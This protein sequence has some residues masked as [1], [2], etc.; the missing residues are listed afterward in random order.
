V[1][2]N[3]EEYHQK[4]LGCWMGKNIGG[5]LGAPFEWRR[6]LNNVSFYTQDLSGEPLPNDDLDIQLLWLVALEERGLD[7]DARTLSEYWTLYVT[8]HWSEYGTAKINLRS[9]L[10]PP[11]SGS[12]HN[13]YKDSC[14]SFIRS[15]IWACIAPGNPQV[16]TYYAYQ[17]A[18][19]DHGDGEG[20]YAEVFIA[21]LE[22]VAFVIS[23][24]RQLIEIALSYIPDSCG[25]SGAVLDALD[26]YRSGKTWQEARDHILANYR[27]STF[28][29]LLHHTSPED[30]AKGF[31]EGKRG[32]DAPSNIG[33][34]VIGLLYGEGDFAQSV[35]TAVNC[36]EDTDCTAAT[37]GSIFGILHGIQ[38]IPEK[39]IA[40]IGRKIKTACLNLGEL[41]NYGNQLP[42]D[43]DELTR[44]TEKIARQVILRYHLDMQLSEDQSSNLSGVTLTSLQAGRGIERLLENMKGPLY[45]FDFFEIA[46][47][48]GEGPL[49]RDNIPTLIR[50]RIYNTY[51]V[52]ATLNIHWY[53]PEGWQVSPSADGVVFSFP[54]HLGDPIELEYQVCAPHVTQSIN[55]AV[56]EITSPGRPTVM[57]LPIVFQN[58]NLQS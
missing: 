48:Y 18:I 56:V 31:G 58:G 25:V 39:W 46:I 54:V 41:G 29:N 45:T 35:C 50:L 22:S 38:A 49:L 14:G 21:A 11:L 4:V 37:A 8:P 47:D 7:L 23:D 40:P 20:V 43:V 3:F 30:W 57:L 13:Q 24:I 55:R 2:L 52:Q 34:L 42:A 19:L 33:M 26:S 28:F 12:L 15:E 27:G 1:I 36:G 6:Q 44:R 5:T 17:D 32:W 51:K 9:G 10:M 53:T 16:A